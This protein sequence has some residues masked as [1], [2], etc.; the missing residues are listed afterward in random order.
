MEQDRDDPA[1][2]ME[3]TTNEAAA[4]LSGPVGFTLSAKLVRGLRYLDRGPVVGKRGSRL[5]SRKSA[6]GA[7]LAEYGTNPNMW[8]QGSWREV[9]EQLRRTGDPGFNDLIETLERRDPPDEWDPD[10]AEK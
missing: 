6:L 4:Y 7:F 5:V 3:M 9:A 8:T 1:A 2:D 10:Q